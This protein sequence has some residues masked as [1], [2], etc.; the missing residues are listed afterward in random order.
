MEELLAQSIDAAM[1][2]SVKGIEH[3][4]CHRRYDGTGK[5]HRLP[6]RFSSAG[7]KRRASGETVMPNLRVCAVLGRYDVPPLVVSRAF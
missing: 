4:A 6:D 1:R 2:A 3:Q 7:M 5:P